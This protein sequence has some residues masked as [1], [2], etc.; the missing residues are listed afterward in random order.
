MPIHIL[1]LVFTLVLMLAMT[2]EPAEAQPATIWRIGIMHVG[3][4]HVPPSLDPLLESLKTLGYEEGGN[5]RVDWRNLPDERAA[6]AT[7]KEFVETG[8]N[9]IV[10]FEDQSVRASRAATSETPIVFLHVLDPVAEGYVQSLSHP[11]GNITGPV[12]Y[13]E[14]TA[15]YLELFKEI[16]PH[17]RRMLLLIDKNDPTTL[18]QVAQARD[19]AQHLKLELVES[20]VSTAAEIEQVF[21]AVKPGDVEGVMIASRNLQTKFPSLIIRLAARQ[22]LPLAMHRREFVEQGALFSYAP[23]VASL[24]PAGAR[25]I[26]KILK[27][28]KPAE[29]PVEFVARVRLTINLRTA[30][31]LGLSIPPF[32]IARADEVIE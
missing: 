29:L 28:A 1:R 14:L 30:A 17:L 10:A 5:L 26:D 4:D 21:A 22:R 2:R 12:A 3:I 8:V 27:G 19:A 9:L 23:N 24:G 18:H 13:Q 7:A 15:K 11:G 16:A 20:H 32:T 6:H 31:A 25:Y